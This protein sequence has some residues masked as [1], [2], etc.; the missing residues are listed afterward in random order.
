[1]ALMMVNNHDEQGKD[2]RS[3]P[4]WSAG[5][6]TEVMLRLLRGIAGGAVAG[7]TGRGASAGRLAR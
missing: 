6:K 3:Q 4:R 2:Y 5:K 1:M 7:A